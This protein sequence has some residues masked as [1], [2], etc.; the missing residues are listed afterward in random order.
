MRRGDASFLLVVVVL[1][2]L[3]VGLI[4]LSR[5]SPNMR[6]NL[7]VSGPT[8][9][10]PTTEPV[11]PTTSGMQE[12]KRM[13]VMLTPVSLAEYDQ[14]GTATLTEENGQVKVVLNLTVPEG[15]TGPQP[16]HIHVGSCPG[17]GTVKYPLTN[18]VDGKSETMIETT[19]RA[20]REQLPLAINVHKSPEESKVYT[21]CG[22]LQ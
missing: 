11:S 6:V 22:P 19:L 21:S 17:V 1:A 14:S 8:G 12:A 9:T 2:L 16:A 15:I 5:Y 4:M 7:N 3:V 13:E 10:S 20:L 18:V